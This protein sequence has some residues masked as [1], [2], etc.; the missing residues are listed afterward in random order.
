MPTE[1]FEARERALLGQRYETLYAAP[2]DSAARGVTVSALRTTPGTF[3]AKADMAL[4]PSPFCK[5]AFVVREETFKPGRHPYHHAGVFYSQE[6][7]AASAAPLLGVKPGMRVLD[8]CAAP[9]GKSSQLAAALQGQGLLVSNE[10][11]AARADILKSNLER[12]GVPNAVILNEAPARIAEALPEFFDRVLVDAP[13]SGE[14]MFRKE[15]VAVTQHSEALVKQCA[16]LGAQILDCAAAV[17]APGGQLVYSTCT[18]APE[19]DEGQVAAFLQRHPEF[20]L[21]DALGN[22]DYTFGSEGEANRTGGLPLDVTRVRRVWPCQGGEGHFMARLVKA[23]TP[24]ALPA[25]GEYSPEEQ[26]WPEYPHSGRR[27]RGSHP[28]PESGSLAGVCGPVLPGAGPAP[29]GGAWRRGAA[30]CAV[31]PDHAPCAAGRRVCGQCAERPFCAGAPPLYSVRCPVHQPGGAD[32]DRPPHRGISLG[33]G[34]RGPRRRRWLVLRDRGWLA[35][36][37]RQSVR[38]AGE[39]PLPQGAA[40][41]VTLFFDKNRPD[42]A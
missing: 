29:G 17:L 25:P 15:A 1:Y 2:S 31:P 36:G 39:K 38:R 34:D 26:L 24:R 11:V 14:G 16:E 41:V 35:P 9:G 37:R 10:Y 18:F 6:P 12:M 28:G 33:P 8:L 40:P 13:C 42:K 27:G 30:A 21:A 5:A 7:S 3:A 19:E 32:A 22:V 23:G 20:T 4:E